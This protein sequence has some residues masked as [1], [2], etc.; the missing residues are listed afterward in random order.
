MAFFEQLGK[1]ISDA[2]QGASQQVKNF[3]EIT[4][5]NSTISDKEKRIA[6]LFAEIGQAYYEKHKNDSHAESYERI[7][8][9]SNLNA[10]IQRCREEIK[11]IKGVEKCP[12]CGADVPLNAAF[13]NACG[14]RVPQTEKTKNA[15]APGTTNTCPICRK[16]VAAGNLYCNVCGAKIEQDNQ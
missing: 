1:K 6:Q 8:E 9:I 3:A 14:T 16:P 5:L 4:R 7:A 11:Q 2:G 15:A 10:E 12:N 13:C